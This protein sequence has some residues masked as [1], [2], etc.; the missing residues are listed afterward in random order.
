MS[1]AAAPSV[2]APNALALPL[3]LALTVTFTGCAST[4][5]NI[6]ELGR[7]D[8]ATF[9][10]LVEANKLFQQQDPRYPAL[11]DEL[12]E[13]PVSAGWLTRNFV[14]YVFYERE[15]LGLHDD[16]DLLRAAARIDDPF[17]RF[18]IEEIRVIGGQAV[19]VLVQD[20]LLHKQAQVRQVGI[21][22]LTVVGEPAL[23]RLLEVAG[24]SEPRHR[25]TAALALSGFV[26]H[27]PAVEALTRL[28]HDRDFAVRADAVRAL[29]N[30]GPNVTPLLH[31]VL[32]NDDDHFV[33]RVAVE[34]LAG[35]PSGKTARLLAAYLA[36]CKAGDDSRGYQ[37]AQETLQEL[38]GA[39]G[40][41]TVEAWQRWAERQ[42]LDS[43]AANSTDNGARPRG[44]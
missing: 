35:H 18:A 20:L 5:S 29:R 12:L 6:M 19:P 38:A 39:R 9:Q 44:S 7:L 26:E 14:H 2:R 8:E 4:E 32:Q 25:R 17:E 1:S 30:A 21:E 37:A 10:K 23:P 43:S 24:S 11:R 16:A 27:P 31:D 41:R 36:K 13:D 42:P 22:L 15:I 28:V 3:A 33:R 40:P 34:S